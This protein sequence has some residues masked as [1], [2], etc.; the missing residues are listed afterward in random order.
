LIVFLYRWKIK[1]GREKQFEENWAIVTEA[2]KK[3]CGSYGSRLHL[4]E[5]N[6][7]V[8]YAQWPDSETR[9]RC[10]LLDL[11]SIEARKLMRDAIEYSFPDQMLR[12]KSDYLIFHCER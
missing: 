3:D 10:E 11:S 2:I 12:I 6:E 5:N 4:A 9:D 8:G 7:Y 1:P